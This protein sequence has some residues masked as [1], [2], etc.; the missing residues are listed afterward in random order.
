M[1]FPRKIRTSPRVDLTAMID[2]VFLLLIFFMIS[3]TFVERPGVKIELPQGGADTLRS[4]EREIRVYLG[5]D[6][7]IYL[8][9]QAVTAAQLKRRLQNRA[10]ERPA[11]AT[12]VLMADTKVRHGAVVGV[13]D[14][15][16]AA[17]IA[18]VAIAT[19]TPPAEDRPSQGEE[20]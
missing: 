13:I 11:S 10:L 2:V 19:E 18:H 17:G 14:M 20:Q 3:T 5:A 4:A 16:K 9:R 8:D 6:G 15:A 7:E 1:A 12:L